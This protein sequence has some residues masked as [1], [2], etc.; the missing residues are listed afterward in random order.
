MFGYISFYK[1]KLTEED[2]MTFKSYYCGLCKQLGKSYNQLV[3]LGLSYDFTFL[4]ILLDSLNDNNPNYDL[5]PC[6]RYIGKKKNIVTDNDSIIFSTDM[7]IALNYYKLTDDIKD[8]K[9]VKAF[10]LRIPYKRHIKK[11]NKKYE[12]I[13]DEISLHL[14]KLSDLEK[15]KCKSIDE[16][17]HEFSLIMENIFS[18]KISLG[19]LGYNLG[20][21][22]YILDA[23]DD[24]DEDLKNKKYNPILLKY[25]YTGKADEKKTIIEEIDFILTYTLS[26]IALEYEKQDIKRNKGLLDNIIYLGLRLKKDSILYKSEEKQ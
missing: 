16:I 11:I 13:T 8:D 21:F 20:K 6:I 17:S 19:K 23:F 5:Q 24:L 22:I 10:L 12:I 4:V 18:Y 25:N 14:K 2:F 3:R 7:S 9:S 26:Q 1:S 15:S